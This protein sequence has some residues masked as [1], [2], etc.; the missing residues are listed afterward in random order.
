MGLRLVVVARLSDAKLRSKLLPLLALPE[1]EQLTLVRRRPLALER[2]VNLCPPAAIADAAAL[3]EPLRALSLLRVCLA[4]PRPSALIAFYFVPHVAYIETARRLFGIPTIPV[5]ISAEDVERAAT[6]PFFARA[7]RQAHAVG[8]RGEGSRR[9]LI[10]SG[11]RA[12]RVFAPP[13]TFEAGPFEPLDASLEHELVFVGDLVEVKRLDWLLEAVAAARRTRPGLRLALVGDGPLRGSLAARA[14]QPDLR[15]AVAFLGALPS[16]R[17]A[18][19]LRASRALVLTS[20]YEG[21]PM[22]MLEAFCCGVP[23]IVPD[24][25]DVASVARDGENALVL[26]APSIAA[27]AAAIERLLGDEALRARLAAGALRTREA[28]L[29]ESSLEA[30]ATSWRTALRGL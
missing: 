1:V 19:A 16:E 28:V 29:R 14:E 25:G 26:S 10:A 5:A 17:V 13:N 20:R 30:G 12:E 2:V 7:L 15:G 22:S 3:A 18:R 11:L 8:V 24:V 4:R 6:S 23:A 21:L 9:R 27:Y